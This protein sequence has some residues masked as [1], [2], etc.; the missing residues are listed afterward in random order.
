MDSFIKVNLQ[1]PASFET[2]TFYQ[3]VSI[4]K[5]RTYK[6]TYAYFINNVT[7]DKKEVQSND[8]VYLIEPSTS[9]EYLY[10]IIY[11]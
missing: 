8:K 6:I 1:Y 9:L 3:T 7:G 11:P 4:Y 10:N 2:Q 5:D